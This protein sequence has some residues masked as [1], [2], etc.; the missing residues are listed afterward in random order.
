MP[1]NDVVRF[2]VSAD[3]RELV[4]QLV[5]KA[6]VPTESE[7]MRQLVQ[8]AAIGYGLR[9]PRRMLR[10]IALPARQETAA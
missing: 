2:R 8:A 4:D 6:G 10:Q 7:L 3:E 5:A 9:R 1:R